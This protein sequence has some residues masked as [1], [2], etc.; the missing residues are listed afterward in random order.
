MRW[1]YQLGALELGGSGREQVGPE[2]GGRECQV[3][4]LLAVV[5]ARPRACARALELGGGGREQVSPD[6]DGRG[7]QVLSPPRPNVMRLDG[8]V[9]S[10]LSHSLYLVFEYMEHDF[11]ALSGQRFMELLLGAAAD[12]WSAGCILAELLAVKPIMPG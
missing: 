10:R 5:R 4:P 7:R 11:A 3:P 12:L 2:H 8:I 1:V 6:S 9:T